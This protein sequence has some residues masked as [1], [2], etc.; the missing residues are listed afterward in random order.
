LLA[1]CT[2]IRRT[3][4]EVPADSGA[5]NGAAS[6]GV[7]L[8]LAQ[9]ESIQAEV[10][11]SRP[12]EATVIIHGLLH[13]GATRVHEVQQQRLADGFV[14]TVI[15]ARSRSAVASLALIPF[16]RSVIL[17]LEGMPKGPC[18]VVANGVT[19]MLIVP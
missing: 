11:P 19:A 16:E 2:Q 1:G 10:S 6:E 7:V 3:R 14:L 9:V 4:T 5:S 8:K 13:D 17:N 15:T 18:K 12:Q